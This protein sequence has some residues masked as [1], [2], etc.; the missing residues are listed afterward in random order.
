MK[1]AERMTEKRLRKLTTTAGCGVVPG[2]YVKVAKLR[3]GSLAKYFILR[4]RSIG[5]TLT[6][7]KYPEL[8]LAAAFE[9]AK[10]W[11]AK[12]A[13][14]IDPAKEEKAARAALNP[15]KKPNKD[16]YTY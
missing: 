8:S 11:K 15:R 6:L 16:A 9:K 10:N 1:S 3:D 5:R 13:Q 12:V 4:E 14:G 7:G 2:F